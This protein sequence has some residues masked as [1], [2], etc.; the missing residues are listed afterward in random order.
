MEPIFLTRK[1]V[2]LGISF[3]GLSLALGQRNKTRMLLVYCPHS[4]PAVSLSKL[5]AILE[6]ALE[7]HRNGS[8]DFKIY[9][10][11]I[12]TAM[13]SRL[14]CNKQYF[15]GK[16]LVQPMW[17]VITYMWFLLLAEREQSDAGGAFSVLSHTPLARFKFSVEIPYRNGELVKTYPL[18]V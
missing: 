11:A 1:P 10:E 18:R 12:I 16:S 13:T 3:E 4:C 17:H 6:A 8:R 2:C 15:F 7:S 9:S 14:Q 5:V